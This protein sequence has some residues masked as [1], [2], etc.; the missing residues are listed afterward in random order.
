MWRRTFLAG[1]IEAAAAALLARTALAVPSP[2]LEHPGERR[3]DMLYRPLGS[4]GITVSAI[5]LGGFHIGKPDEKTAMA[6]MHRAIDEGIR[7]FDNC[8]D[9]NGG[10]S[11][12]RMGEALAGGKR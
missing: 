2:T 12:R 4:T 10:E 3:G 8:W 1:S 11:E 9:Y 5:G 6:I 7:F